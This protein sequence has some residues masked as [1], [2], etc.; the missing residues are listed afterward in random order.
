[1]EVD[2]IR[3]RSA[4]AYTEHSKDRLRWPPAG[5]LSG[6][7][8]LTTRREESL[9]GNPQNYLVE[10]SQRSY[11]SNAANFPDPDHVSDYYDL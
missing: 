5:T 11:A 2:T 10:R 7:C 6:S 3:V 1:M 4:M 9:D 8:R